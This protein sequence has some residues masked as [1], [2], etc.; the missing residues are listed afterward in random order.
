MNGYNNHHNRRVC[1]KYKTG[2]F[3]LILFSDVGG[4]INTTFY[5]SNYKASIARDKHIAEYANHSGVVLRILSNTK[6]SSEKWDYI[7]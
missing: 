6:D 1:V 7:P 5:D 4:K 3:M 2:S